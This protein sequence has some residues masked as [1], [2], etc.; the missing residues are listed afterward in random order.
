MDAL[1]HPL[2]DITDEAVAADVG[3]LIMGSTSFVL[4]NPRQK[5]GPGGIIGDGI[6]LAREIAYAPPLLNQP[7][8]TRT[9]RWN[10]R[11]SLLP[12]VSYAASPGL[13]LTL[14]TVAEGHCRAFLAEATA[15][16]HEGY[17][18]KEVFIEHQKAMRENWAMTR[19][20]PTIAGPEIYEANMEPG[21][22]LLFVSSRGD[23][24]APRGM[25]H[26]IVSLS[27]C[28]NL[29]GHTFS[30]DPVTHQNDGLA[31]STRSQL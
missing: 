5:P 28:T 17:T 3:R 8:L 24:T 1:K 21:N 26:S 19:I 10:A 14:L 15:D 30:I 12:H 6:V 13:N 7:G 2:D 16:V 25:W 23:T 27:A 18:D 31:A 4:Y 20:D 22:S 9:S 29:L 11:D